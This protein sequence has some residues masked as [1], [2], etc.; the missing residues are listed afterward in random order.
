VAHHAIV[1]RS[2]LDIEFAPPVDD[3]RPAPRLEFL[4]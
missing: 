4:R 2:V 3:R 1:V